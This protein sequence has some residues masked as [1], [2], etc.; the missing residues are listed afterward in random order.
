MARSENGHGQRCSPSFVGRSD[1]AVDGGRE[2]MRF[3]AQAEADTVSCRCY[4]HHVTFVTRGSQPDRLADAVAAV[5][6]LFISGHAFRGEI[7]DAAFDVGE[8]DAYVVAEVVTN[9]SSE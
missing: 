4:K 1:H 2:E 8:D 3:G 9:E 5:D 6:P 7:F